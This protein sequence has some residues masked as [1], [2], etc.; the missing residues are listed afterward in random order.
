MYLVDYAQH[1]LV[2]VPIA[3]SPTP[4]SE[5]VEGSAAGRA[6]RAVE[7]VAGFDDGRPRLWVPLLDGVERLGIIGIRFDPEV[8]VDSPA[9]RDQVRW[10]AHLTGHL[11]ASKSPYGDIFHRLRAAQHRSVGSELIWSLLPP[12]TMACER[13]VISGLLEPAEQVAGDVFDYAVE[14]GIAHIAIFDG[15]GHDLQSS[16][17]G[18]LTLAAYRNGRRRQEDMSAIAVRIDETLLDFAAD[19]YATGVIGQLD[20]HNGIF[21]YCNAGHPAPLLL[22]SGRVVRSLDAGRRILLGFADQ[23]ATIGEEHLEPG[24]V[25]VLYTDGVVEAR[26][27]SRQFFG[28]GRFIELLERSA[29]DQHKAPEMLRGVVRRVL[30][31]Q[32]GVLQDDAS[33]LL[34]EWA[35]DNGTKMSAS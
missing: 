8:D 19:T 18:A 30:E 15:T 6:F 22:R 16:V 5:D 3:G 20:L 29:A 2:P 23:S 26:D 25:I 10:F 24:D 21:R 7:A 14:D 4:P 11:V 31:H 27:A 32:H 33:I 34:I 1:A 12:L 35:A 9:L 28:L 13:A 17:I